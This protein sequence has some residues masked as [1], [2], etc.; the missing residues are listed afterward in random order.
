MLVV[1]DNEALTSVLK[2]LLVHEGY[3]VDVAHD[4]SSAL[5]AVAQRRPDLVVLDVVIPTPDGFEVCRR[6]K[7]DAATRL[8]PVVLVTAHN[9][10]EKR[11]EGAQAGADDFLSKPVDTQ[12]LLARVRSLVRLKRYTD[13]LDSASSIIMMLAVMVESRDGHTVGH[14]HGELRSGARPKPGVGRRRSTDAAT[15]R[16]SS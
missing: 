16:V 1:D 3:E 7:Q 14:S 15:G 9:E 6:L 10:R 2:R 4:G 11:I 8:L 12:E 5:A 13:D